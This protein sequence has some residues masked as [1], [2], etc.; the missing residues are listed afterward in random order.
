MPAAPTVLITG[1]SS[2][3]GLAA[4]LEMKQ[5]GWEVLATARKE[6][7]LTLL[8]EKGLTPLHLDVSDAESVRACAAA[9]SDRVTGLVNNAGFG[10]PGALEDLSREAMR[11]QFETNVFGLQELTNALLPGMIERKSG[12]I[13]HVS[14]VVGRVALPF[15]GIY[16]ASKF[17]VEALADAQRVE[18]LGTGVQIS[19][20]EPGPII[21]RFSRNAVQSSEKDLAQTQ[22]RFATLYAKELADR[23]GAIGSKAFALPPEAVA[24]RIAHALTAP[25]ARRR[26]RV[27]LPAHLGALMA[28]FAPDALIDAILAAELRKRQT[29]ARAFQATQSS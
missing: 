14:S 24:R 16:S 9:C 7:D 11:R 22:S 19:L 28:R 15:L 8:Q 29:A 21:T 2:G 6:A 12:R 10:Q 25:R 27:T 18:L 4:A 1:C 17:A 13:V 3:I 26:Y 20:V 23:D 5:R